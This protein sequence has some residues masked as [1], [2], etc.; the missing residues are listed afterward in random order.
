MSVRR[1]CMKDSRFCQSWREVVS[2][3]AKMREDTAS[4]TREHKLLSGNLG[5]LCQAVC[6]RILMRRY[7]SSSRKDKKWIQEIRGERLQEIAE[8]ASSATPSGQ[9]ISR[10]VPR[11][12]RVSWGPI[13]A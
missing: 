11:K 2:V 8:G 6:Q 1:H 7:V 3:A 9:L 12:K 5:N 10:V 13:I 4:V